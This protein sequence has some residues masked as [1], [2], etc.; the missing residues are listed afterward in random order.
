MYMNYFLMASILLIVSLSLK[1]NINQFYQ[2]FF[3]LIQF[4]TVGTAYTYFN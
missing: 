4:S 3:Y 2:Y 1:I